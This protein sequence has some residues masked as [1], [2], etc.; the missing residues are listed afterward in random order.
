MEAGP[1]IQTLLVAGPF[2]RWRNPPPLQSF[3][4][5]LFPST[6]VILN[7][8]TRNQTPNK[9]TVQKRLNPCSEIPRQMCL[10][11]ALLNFANPGSSA[12]GLSN[13][14]MLATSSGKRQRFQ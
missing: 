14:Q 2:P 9:P 4:I 3:K 11:G 10:S 7:L 1:L 13:A 12:S 8:L 5:P 6:A